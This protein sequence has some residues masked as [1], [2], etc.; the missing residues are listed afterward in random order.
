MVNC[1]TIFFYHI[2][3]DNTAKI[4]LCDK[5]LSLVK[6][7]KRNHVYFPQFHKNG[8]SGMIKQVKILL[9]IFSLMI[10]KVLKK[11]KRKKKVHLLDLNIKTINFLFYFYVFNSSQ[12]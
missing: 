1:I 6:N 8:P 5:T 9:P 4:L 3:V 11:K 10:L 7:D 2:L 12:K